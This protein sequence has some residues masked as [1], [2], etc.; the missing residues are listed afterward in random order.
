[1][2]VWNMINN[3]CPQGIY[4]DIIKHINFIIPLCSNI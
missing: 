3:Y 4:Q 1:L 2:F